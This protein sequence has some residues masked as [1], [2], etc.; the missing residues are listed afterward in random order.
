MERGQ[1]RSEPVQETATLASA[2]RC[3]AMVRGAGGRGERPGPRRGPRR[4]GKLSLWCLRCFS[5][6]DLLFCFVCKC[7]DLRLSVGFPDAT[8]RRGAGS[9]P[10]FT[11][12][13]GT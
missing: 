5:A 13:R 9:S 1:R 3:F 6:S 8:G 7:E 11:T 10:S 4:G 2:R 12:C